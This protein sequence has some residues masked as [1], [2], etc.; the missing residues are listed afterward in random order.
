MKT[1]AILLAI[2]SLSSFAPA[3][4]AEPYTDR[5]RVLSVRPLTERIPVSREECWNDRQRGYE[6]RRVTR[7]DT[8]AAIGPGTVLGAIV[9]GVAGHQVGSG[10]GNDAATAAGAVIGGL[11]GNQADRDHGNVRPG[12]RVTEIERVPVDRNVQRCRVVDEVREATVGF[13]VRYEYAGR[14]FT[15]RLPQDPGPNLRVRVDVQPIEFDG[16][17]G[18]RPPSYR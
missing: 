1:K 16:P 12:E 8:G 5:A 18:P 15:T 3:A 4:F 7:S 11:I 10:R 13:D 6:E 9:G 14:Q 17:R 2:A